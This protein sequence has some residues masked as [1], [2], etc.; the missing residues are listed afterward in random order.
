MF[1]T[2]KIPPHIISICQKM[3]QA[4]FDCFLVGGSV[5]DLILD[6]EVKD[7]DLTTNATPEQIQAIFPDHFYENDFGTVGIKIGIK[8][9]SDSFYNDISTNFSD[10]QVVEITPYRTESAYSDNRHP[11]QVIFSDNIEDDL[12]RR[13][14]T[15][16]A[17]A[18]SL[19]FDNRGQLLGFDRTLDMFNGQEDIGNK[20]IRTVGNP[21]ERFQEDSLRLMRALR[22]M[23][24][25]E[26]VI[27]NQ[28]MQSLTKNKD[29]L[30]NIAKERIKEE[31]VKIL[32]SNNPS[33]TIVLCQKIGILQYIL[34]ELEHG[35]GV[36]Q[37]HS[38]IYDVW[39]HNL[40]SLQYA[41]D[42]KF[43]L[44]I[45]VAALLHDIG[46]VTAKRTIKGQITFYGHEVVGARITKQILKDLKF[47]GDF[48]DKVVKLVRWHMFFS[49]TEQ[50]TLSAVRR[51]I[52]NVG[53]ENI[54]DLIKL[55]ECDRIGMGRPSENPYRLRQ[56]RV[57]IEQAL[58]DP[59]SV[60]QLKIN[61]NQII[62]LLQEPAGPKIGLILNALMEEVL[63]NP[64]L[65]TDEHLSK[66]TVELSHLNLSELKNL[67][68]SG[69]NKQK[70]VE[71][72]E[73]DKIKQKH[74]V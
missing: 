12:I 41:A 4:N 39:E 57:M 5:R 43:D 3:R 47:S 40:R 65:N 53:A 64:E 31:F 42:Q 21:D 52:V 54:W 58:R 14:F 2:S 74:R 69:K 7:W 8:D 70:E 9:E 20:I 10:V 49:D 35:I 27:N 22:F 71:E 73:L 24:E 37:N 45:R 48:T 55:R 60:R 72:G 66:R 63:E 44:A 13:D 59:I 56:Y 17:I 50:I 46:K 68:E 28:T 1:E 6:R 18:L 32:L 30:Q 15:M 51:M 25:L 23:A 36:E 29:L 11:D 62:N 26:F 19:K 38:H 33:V 16:N 34:P 67:A 61:G